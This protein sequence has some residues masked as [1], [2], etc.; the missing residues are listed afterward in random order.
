MPPLRLQDMY[1]CKR[2]SR[3]G[4]WTHLNVH[5]LLAGCALIGAIGKAS[6]LAHLI[7]VDTGCN[8]A[9]GSSRGT[10][11]GGLLIIDQ[12]TGGLITLRCCAT[13]IR[14]IPIADM[15][16]CTAAR[17][18][19]WSNSTQ[20]QSK[21]THSQAG[22]E[23]LRVALATARAGQQGGVRLADLCFACTIVATGATVQRST[24]YIINTELEL[25]GRHTG[26]ICDRT[27]DIAICIAILQDSK[28]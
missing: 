8:I 19:R 1:L 3:V 27:A 24:G 25:G 11:G 10:R 2:Y 4:L 22:K 21:R 7:A 5:L 12:R 9:R 28:D 13:D 23:I 17:D 26:S 18:G 14:I 16:G 20:A 6:H 15:I